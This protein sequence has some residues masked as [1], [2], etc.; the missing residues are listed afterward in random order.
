MRQIYT[1]QY[2]DEKTREWNIFE[3]PVLPN[4]ILCSLLR[5][6]F[7]VQNK[8]SRENSIQRLYIIFYEI[9]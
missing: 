4:G 9:K 6:T 8:L 2:S 5:F 7:D 3:T 1:C